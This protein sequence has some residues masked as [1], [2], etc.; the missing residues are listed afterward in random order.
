M[1]STCMLHLSSLMQIYILSY[2]C[3][4]FQS[5]FRIELYEYNS[6]RLSMFRI[7]LV[8][9]YFHLGNCKVSFPFSKN[10][11]NFFFNHLN[12]LLAFYSFAHE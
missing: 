7:F 5:H 1:H 6:D 8:V 10:D 12:I 4:I 3:E 11:L 9:V 2:I